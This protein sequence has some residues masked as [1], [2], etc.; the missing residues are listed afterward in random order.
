[1]IKFLVKKGFVQARVKGS[2]VVMKSL[3]GQNVVSIP[4]H[5][6]LDRGTLLAILDD[7]GIS[8]N[9]FMREWK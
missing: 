2:H 1:M 7:A 6:E 3:D 4:L 9:E 5:N 8:R